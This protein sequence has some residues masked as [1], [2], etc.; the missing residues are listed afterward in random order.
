M[1]DMHTCVVCLMCVHKWYMFECVHGMCLCVCIINILCKHLCI[2]M[3]RSEQD[4]HCLPLLF[5][6]LLSWGVIIT[7]PVVIILS[8]LLSLLNRCL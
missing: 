6:K 2:P 5:R 3:K 7:E 4:F 1:S 8:R